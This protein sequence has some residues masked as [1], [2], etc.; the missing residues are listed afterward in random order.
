MH[1]R[2]IQRLSTALHL[3]NHLADGAVA[4]DEGMGILGG[5][6]DCLTGDEMQP[7]GGAVGVEG[8][9]GGGVVGFDFVGHIVEGFP[10]DGLA[11]FQQYLHVDVVAV[12]FRH[13]LFGRHAGG[14]DIVD[15]EAVAVDFDA[16]AFRIEQVVVF[17]YSKRVGN[18]G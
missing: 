4:D 10:A 6:D 18:D 15:E 7:G 2:S 17:T 8:T 3:R 16:T 11:A 14:L 1:L 12:H 5:E 13:L 9:V